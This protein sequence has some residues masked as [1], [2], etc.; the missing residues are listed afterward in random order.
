MNIVRRCI[1]VCFAVIFLALSVPALAQEG[2]GGNQGGENPS[3]EPVVIEEEPF[4]WLPFLL[5]MPDVWRQFSPPPSV[6]G[7]S[8]SDWAP[9]EPI[10]VIL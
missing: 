6:P 9:R 2:C 10:F 7:G 4:N 5:P 1:I 8:P 3:P